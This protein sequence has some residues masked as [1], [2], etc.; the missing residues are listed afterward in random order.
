MAAPLDPD[1][2]RQLRECGID[3]DRLGD[4]AKAWRSLHERFGRRATL[5][6]RYAL[7]AACRGVDGHQL[8]R[9]VRDRLAAE[10]LRASYP[11]FAVVERSD[12]VRRD[13]VEVVAY[14]PAW[15]GRFATWRNR[16]AGAL[17]GTARRID[18]VGSTAVPGL[19]AKP[20]IDVQASVPDIEDEAA[21][22]PALEEAGVA[23]RSRDAAHRYF[24]PSGG[25]PRAVQV[26]VCPA[27]SAWERDH[28]LFRDFLRSRTDVADAYGRLK[29]L[30]A[31]RYREDRIAYNEAKT[32][33]ILDAME[34]AK[35]WAAKAGWAVGAESAR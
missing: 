34:E 33:F 7:E 32:N 14:D 15:P 30:L 26:H 10:V 17:L 21:Y 2:G 3:P 27:G 22:V 12:R 29:C 13:P 9:A 6:D 8:D 5:I 19:P 23:F 35:A 4:P 16:L 11:G 1:L 20:V 25:R 24:R 28:L 18:H 31:A